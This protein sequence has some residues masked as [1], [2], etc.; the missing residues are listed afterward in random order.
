MTIKI[1]YCNAPLLQV[2][3]HMAN[4]QKMAISTSSVLHR[5]ILYTNRVLI[6]PSWEIQLPICARGREP[7]WVPPPCFRE[8]RGWAVSG[9][10]R[11]GLS[12]NSTVFRLFPKRAIPVIWKTP[13]QGVSPGGYKYSGR[14]TRAF[15]QDTGSPRVKGLI[16]HLKVAL[17][18]LT[19]SGLQNILELAGTRP[20]QQ[21]SCYLNGFCGDGDSSLTHHVRPVLN[22]GGIR[23]P[24][25]CRMVRR[26]GI[27]PRT[28]CW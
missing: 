4:H 26:A 21:A 9:L 2:L 18:G 7:N 6:E 3:H 11:C 25:G 14:L 10:W 22:H 24:V 13:S 20:S 5:C 17:R 8:S 27:E 28:T 23:A 19:L 12:L 15:Y 16:I 1:V